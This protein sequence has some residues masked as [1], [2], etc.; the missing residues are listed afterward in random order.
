MSRA[1]VA[2]PAEQLFYNADQAAAR[3]GVSKATLLEAVAAGRLRGKR[4]G[5]NGGGL[6]LFSRDQLAQWFDSLEDA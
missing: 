5:V 6:Y 3:C 1:A 4:S 2:A